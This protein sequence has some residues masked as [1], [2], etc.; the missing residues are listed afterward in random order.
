MQIMHETMDVRLRGFNS[1]PTGM[2]IPLD[3]PRASISENSSRLGEGIFILL[4]YENAIEKQHRGVE[5][6]NVKGTP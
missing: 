6:T 3:P 4:K 2:N 1:K 5:R